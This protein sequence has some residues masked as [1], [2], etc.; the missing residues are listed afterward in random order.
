MMTL[1]I[2]LF[3]YWLVADDQVDGLA[4]ELLCSCMRAPVIPP[5]EELSKAL[6]HRR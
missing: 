3:N 4:G 5:A 2:D 1:A 6:C